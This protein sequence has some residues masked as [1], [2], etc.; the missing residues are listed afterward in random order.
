MPARQPSADCPECGSSASMVMQSRLM[1][2]GERVR[3]RRCLDCG[4]RWYTEQAPEVEVARWRLIWENGDIAA[5]R[6][7]PESSKK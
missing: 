7:E 1:P 2:A 6:P 4:H 3:R 5:L